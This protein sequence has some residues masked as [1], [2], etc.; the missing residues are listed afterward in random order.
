M[1]LQRKLLDPFCYTFKHIICAFR[2]AAH[3]PELEDTRFA[4]HHR[5]VIDTQH[6]EQLFARDRDVDYGV[7]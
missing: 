2:T 7:R 3:F 6:L 4:V 5:T 1:N